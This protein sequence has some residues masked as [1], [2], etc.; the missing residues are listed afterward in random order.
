MDFGTK[1]RGEQLFE[2]LQM[3]KQATS[4]PLSGSIF[5]TPAHK[6][7]ANEVRRFDSVDSCDK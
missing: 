3:F 6:D 5:R 2:V 7:I 1:A 4:S